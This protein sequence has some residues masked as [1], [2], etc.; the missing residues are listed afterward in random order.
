[1]GDLRIKRDVYSNTTRILQTAYA[2][3]EPSSLAL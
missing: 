1:M 3:E 2:D